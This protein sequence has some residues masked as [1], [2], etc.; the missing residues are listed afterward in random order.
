MTWIN[1]AKMHCMYHYLHMLRVLKIIIDQL[2]SILHV[3]K[4]FSFI[5]S[6]ILTFYNVFGSCIGIIV[7]SASCYNL[8]HTITQWCLWRP[9][10]TIQ[11][12][13]LPR[14]PLGSQFF[15]GLCACHPYRVSSYFSLLQNLYPAVWTSHPGLLFSFN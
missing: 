4:C 2:C 1:A 15:L 7:S 6:L 12:L 13:P 5:F 8:Y 11:Q 3:T 9:F 14:V 10:M